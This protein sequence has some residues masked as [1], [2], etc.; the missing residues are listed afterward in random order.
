MLSL[1]FFFFRGL[2]SLFFSSSPCR[3]SIPL[4]LIHLHPYPSI[5]VIKF[6]NNHTRTK[7]FFSFSKKKER[8][9]SKNKI[10]KNKYKDPNST[11]NNNDSNHQHHLSSFFPPFS[12]MRLHV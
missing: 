1:I 8:G 11:N 10:N 2:F 3:L 12:L 5:R 6:Y 9:C 4:S 7:G